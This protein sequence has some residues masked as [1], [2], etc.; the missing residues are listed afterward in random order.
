MPDVSR[1]G[2]T[3]LLKISGLARARHAVICVYAEHKRVGH[4]VL[5][6]GSF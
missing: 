5:V 2:A 1:D 3:L 6:G 4:C